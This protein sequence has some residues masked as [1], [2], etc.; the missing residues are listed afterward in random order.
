MISPLHSVRAFVAITVI[1]A[2]DVCGQ[3][4]LLSKVD[5]ARDVLTGGWRRAGSELSV[6]PGTASRC[7]IARGVPAEYQFSIEFTRTRGEDSVVVILPVGNVSPALEIGGWSGVAHGLSRVDGLPTKDTK[8]PTSVRP[9]TFPNN[10]KQTL[11]V[12]VKAEGGN[13]VLVA[14]LNG[15][16]LFRWSGKTSRLEK[17]FVMNLPMPKAIGL[18]VHKSEVTF[19][20]ARLQTAGAVIA[21]PGP[22]DKT[23]PI[24]K[25][26]AQSAQPTQLENL[27]AAGSPGWELFNG[28]AFALATEGGGSFVRARSKVGAADRGAYLKGVNFSEGTIDVELKGG[29]QPGSSFLGVVFHG[30]DGKRYDSVYFRPFNFGHRDPVRRGHAV[31]YMSHPDWPWD[32]LR[33]ERPEEFENPA[34]PEPKPADWFKARIEIKGG[35]VR[36]FVNGA[37]EPCLDVKQMSEVRSGKIGL[38][39]NGIAA[40]RNLKITSD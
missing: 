4:N 3:D 29:A 39:F 38:W 36:V 24:G 34:I 5:V 35:R 37:G 22:Q 18:A 13:A 7:V 21:T 15:E 31:Q 16:S 1:F 25:A 33:K 14:A 40:F 32:K 2:S 19:H 27:G 9:G 30:V 26:P 28:G 20:S 12:S 17:N 6:T 10:V 23:Q 8:N 11:D